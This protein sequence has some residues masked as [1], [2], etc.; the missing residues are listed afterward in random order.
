MNLF[1]EIAQI[2]SPTLILG[3][4]LDPITPVADL[5]DLAAAIPGSHLEVLPG[6]GHGVF[7]DR[8]SEA[9]AIIREFI[10]PTTVRAV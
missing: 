7:R 9:L 8:P 2:R 1:P 3:G 4:E 5:E 6:A 10:A